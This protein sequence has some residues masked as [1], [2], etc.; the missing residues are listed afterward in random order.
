MGASSRQGGRPGD[1][2][3]LIRVASGDLP[4]S[5]YAS[6]QSCFESV[7]SLAA[8]LK[9]ASWIVR[10][11]GSGVCSIQAINGGRQRKR[12]LQIP[13]QPHFI[14]AEL[15]R[16]HLLG[17][18]RQRREL[19]SRTG[20]VA[21]AVTSVYRNGRNRF[22]YDA[23]PRRNQIIDP[24]KITVIAIVVILEI[25]MVKPNTAN[26][27]NLARQFHL[28]LGIHRANVCS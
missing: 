6:A 2:R 7:C 21:D 19:I 20:Q 14:V 18:V 11:D 25:K 15:L 13:L 8:R 28:I 10:V 24:A 16:L 23:H 9:N 12:A 4:R 17:Y 22:E 3:I 27:L 26:Q 1:K 5:G